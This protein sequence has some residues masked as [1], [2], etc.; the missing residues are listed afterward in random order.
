M[1]GRK[2]N[3]KFSLALVLM[4][5]FSLCMPVLAASDDNSLSALNIHNGTLSRDFRY[6]IWEYDVTVEPGTTEL[7]LEPSTSDPNASV[8]SIT[9]TVLVDG[10]AT[11]LINTISESGIPMTY[12]LH[13]KESGEAAAAEETEAPETEAPTEP[14]TEPQTETAQ[15]EA[16]S[17]TEAPASNALQNQVA[18]LKSDSDLMMKIVYGLIALSVILLFFIIN[19]ILKNRDLKDDLKDAENQLAYQ[20]NEFA[21]KERM[22]VTDHYYAP[23]QQGQTAAGN[24]W[25]INQASVQQPIQQSAPAVEETFG[26]RAAAGGYQGMQPEDVPPNRPITAEPEPVPEPAAPVQQPGPV[27]EPQAQP[28]ASQMEPVQPGTEQG[29]SDVDV[30]M[31]E[32]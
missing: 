9:G 3:W 8:T 21:R 12:T 25:N 24:A 26:T 13:V 4:L 5:A 27:S 22:M 19:L 31:V 6:D 28:S 1:E 16:E 23:V 10:E 29:G 2:K 15:T 20:T 14:E 11:V 32:L 30:T 18:K 7:L 17:E